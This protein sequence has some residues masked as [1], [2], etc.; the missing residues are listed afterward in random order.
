MDVEVVVLQV[1]LSHEILNLI[2]VQALSA[3]ALQVETL[4]LGLDPALEGP[5][6]ELVQWLVVQEGGLVLLS[7]DLFEDVVG[8]EE[9]LVVG[10]GGLSLGEEDAAG[11]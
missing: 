5:E 3:E 7:E 6:A 8:L 9:L 10:V 4:L 2:F 11:G 1:V